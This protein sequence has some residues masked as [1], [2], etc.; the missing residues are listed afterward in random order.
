MIDLQ[1][2]VNNVFNR[3]F[4]NNFYITGN[5]DIGLYDVTSEFGLLGLFSIIICAVLKRDGTCSRCVRA[6]KRQVSVT[7]LLKVLGI[8]NSESFLQVDIVIY[9]SGYDGNVA[10]RLFSLY[11]LVTSILE[12]IL[13][14]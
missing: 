3:N 2:A 11:L 14:G 6:L 5:S 7:I 10:N 12:S 8:I 9:F 13:L 1:P 4:S